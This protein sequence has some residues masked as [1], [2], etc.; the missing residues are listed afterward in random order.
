[1]MN[2]ARYQSN[3]VRKIQN[4]LPGCMVLRND[5]QRVQGIPDLL[6]LHKDKWAMLEVKDS[7]DAPMQ[8]NQEY[9]ID[10]LGEMSFASFIYPDIEEDVLGDLQQSF[11]SS[12][13][14]RISKS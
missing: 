2:E 10:R 5:A 4:L 12:R 1:M 8:P 9:Y 6:I 13:E 14:A 7:V 11:R 3:L